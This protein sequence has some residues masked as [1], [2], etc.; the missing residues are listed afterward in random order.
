VSKYIKALLH[1]RFGMKKV[2][3][4][5][6]LEIDYY[7]LQHSFVTNTRFKNNFLDYFV[8][9]FLIESHTTHKKEFSLSIKKKLKNLLS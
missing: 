5:F 6:H 3:N 9:V 7:Y 8:F 4:F 1:S 2:F